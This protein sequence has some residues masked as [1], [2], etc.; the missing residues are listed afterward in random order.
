MPAVCS[1][2]FPGQALLTRQGLALHFIPCRNGPVKYSP[3]I[4][5]S[6]AT[7]DLSGRSNWTRQTSN[8]QRTS[9]I[10][11]SIHVD[12]LSRT[13]EHSIKSLSISASF[14]PTQSKFANLLAASRASSRLLVGSG[15]FVAPLKL[16]VIPGPSADLCCGTGPM[17]TPSGFVPVVYCPFRPVGLGCPYPWLRGSM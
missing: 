15:W 5:Q 2:Q 12:K 7:L 8:K 3:Y 16:P 4:T 17:P 13:H 10:A 6:R 9:I 14:A 11:Y 1:I